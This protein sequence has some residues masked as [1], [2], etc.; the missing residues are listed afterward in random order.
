MNRSASPSLQATVLTPL[1]HII[2]PRDHPSLTD[3]PMH[4]YAIELYQTQ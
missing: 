3:L 4:N 1:N 2:S